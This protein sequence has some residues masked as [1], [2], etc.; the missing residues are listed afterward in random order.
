MTLSIRLPP[1]EALALERYCREHGETKTDV[2]RRLLR[3]HVL[4]A[5]KTPMQIAEEMGIVGM[6]DDNYPPDY[7]ERHGY[8]VKKKLREKHARRHRSVRRRPATA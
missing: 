8:Y 2:V 4:P 3:E 5:R 7:A 6:M 1:D